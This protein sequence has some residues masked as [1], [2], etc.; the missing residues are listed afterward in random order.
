MKTITICDQKY[1]IDCNALT[2]IKYRKIFDR[3]IFEDIQVIENFMITQT[4]LAN[5]LKKDNPKITENEIIKE[6][7]RAML[8]N[9]DEYIEAVTRIAYICIYTANEDIENYGNWIK[10]IKRINTNDEWIVEVTEF[11]VNCFC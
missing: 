2:Y 9:I 6:L 3:G 1:N 8:K 10:S 4:L 5:K 11:A 7:S